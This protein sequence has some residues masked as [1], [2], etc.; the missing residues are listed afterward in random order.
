VAS[1]VF[2]GLIVFSLLGTALSR[3]LNLDPGLI[4]PVTSALTILAGVWAAFD[5]VWNSELPTGA[6]TVAALGAFA[7]LFG[8]RYG[9]PFGRYVYTD[10][11]APILT[12][13]VGPFPILLPFAWLMITAAA[14]RWVGHPVLAGLVAASVDMVMEPVVANV[15]GYWR[16]LEDGPL[17]GGVPILNFC[18]WWVVSTLGAMI[19]KRFSLKSDGGGWMV[20]A[21]HLGLLCGLALLDFVFRK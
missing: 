14:T 18:G 5:G 11:W 2:L 21:G 20:L 16:W 9:L 8:L 3:L 10:A 4:A 6:A 1:K 7:E 19:L 17:P 15:L 12:T 13:A